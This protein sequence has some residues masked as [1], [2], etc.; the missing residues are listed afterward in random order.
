MKHKKQVIILHADR[1]RGSGDDVF[2]LPA[3]IIGM[4]ERMQVLKDQIA[5]IYEQLRD[6]TM[7]AQFETESE[8]QSWRRRALLALEWKRTERAW[9]VDK[10]QVATEAATEGK[11]HRRKQWNMTEEKQQEAIAKRQERLQA[12]IDAHGDDE[13]TLLL[14]K[15][16]RIVI[17]VDGGDCFD[18]DELEA[19]RVTRDYLRLNGLDSQALRVEL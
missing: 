16:Y 12:W 10:W 5:N 9:L 13:L 7:R 18:E 6:Q 2:A 8:F 17:T 1:A 14:L 19:I 15:M 3:T 11:K 4:Q